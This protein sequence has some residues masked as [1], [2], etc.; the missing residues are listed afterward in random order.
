MK[1]QGGRFKTSEYK[2]NPY[3]GGYKARPDTEVYFDEDGFETTKAW[4]CTSS[5]P[6]GK[7]DVQGGERPSTLAHKGNGSNK[8][9]HPAKLSTLRKENKARVTYSNNFGG[10]TY[11]YSDTGGASRFFKQ[12]TSQEE[13]DDYLGTLIR[14]SK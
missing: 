5:C 2:K 10:G 13:L 4:A 9:Q 11:V 3:S 8:V 1:N 6:V 7:L 14:N 12:V